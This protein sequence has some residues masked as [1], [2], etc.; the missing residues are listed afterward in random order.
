VVFAHHALAS[1]SDVIQGEVCSDV[2]SFDQPGFQTQIDSTRDETIVP[3]EGNEFLGGVV[4]MI[5]ND[6]CVTMTRCGDQNTAS[7]LIVLRN[8]VQLISLY[9]EGATLTFQTHSRWM[10]EELDKMAHWTES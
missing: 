7:E 9:P 2:F 1:V 4:G 3:G 8:F 5:G 6:D 10:V